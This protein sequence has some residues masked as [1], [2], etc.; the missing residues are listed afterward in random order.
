MRNARVLTALALPLTLALG[1]C[2]EPSTAPGLRPGGEASLARGN[3]P[4]GSGLDLDIVGAVDLPIVGGGKI[5]ITDAVITNIE[6]VE[7]TV[8]GIVGLEVS[9]TLTGTA[10]D[11]LGGLI[12]L[13]ARPFTADLIVTS[14][15]PGKCSVLTLDL[16]NI[17]V[18]A[19]GLVDAT[20]P[21]N[22]DAKS[23]GAVGSLLCNLGS[24][25]GG[26]A[27]GG[28]GGLVNAINNLL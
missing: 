20:V 16:S 2:A 21:V 13:D 28:A 6:L 4:P 10:V 17:E 19:L 22:V 3:R 14:S 15:G 24:L 25:V 7:S 26:L 8:G 5:T 11:A 1:A 9:G 27:G 23:S 12:T 18:S